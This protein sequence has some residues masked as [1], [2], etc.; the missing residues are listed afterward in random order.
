MD[1]RNKRFE[2]NKMRNQ[3]PRVGSV[4]NCADTEGKDRLIWYLNNGRIEKQ[5]Q[6]EN[7]SKETE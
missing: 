4:K 2:N 3:K 6:N 7:I 1:L 5:K